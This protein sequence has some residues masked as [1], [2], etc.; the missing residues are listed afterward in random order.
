MK[1]RIIGICLI[2]I[3]MVI[4]IIEYI[5]KNKEINTI[6]DF[7]NEVR[8]E[9]QSEEELSIRKLDIFDGYYEKANEKLSELT[10]DE[11]IGQLF[12]VRFPNKNAK[13]ELEKYKFGGYLFFEKDFKG[14]TEDDIKNQIANLQDGAN[15]PLLIAIDE[16][17]GKVVRASSNSN[18]ISEKFKSPSEL[19]KE[20]GFNKIKEDTIRKSE[21]LYNLGINLNLAPVVDVSTDPNDYIYLRTLGENTELTS[22]YAETVISSSKE[23]KVSYTLKHFPGYGNNQ[24][25]HK[26][27]AISD[28]SYEDILNYDLPPF[29]AGISAGA[30]AVLVSHNIV[31]SIDENNPSSLSLAT[32]KLLRDELKFTGV[33]ITDDLDMGAVLNDKDAVVKAVLAENDLIIVTDYKKSIED[34]KKALE[35]GR[36]SEEHINNLVRRI[37][38]WKYYKGLM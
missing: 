22:T 18:L 38:A 33:I 36:I 30:E 20:G 13:E 8:D 19:Y 31:K 26:G 2:V 37:L 17:G 32:H 27:S 11:K 7:Q 25:T 15:I 9:L 6:S 12:L 1:R 24:D 14:K 16:E 35:A 29:L 28:K 10:L 21:F 4:L 23:G 5:P 3:A 34:V